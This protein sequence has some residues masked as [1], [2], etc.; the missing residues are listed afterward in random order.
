MNSRQILVIAVI[1]VI[2]VAV[3]GV[4]FFMESA[5]P[6]GSSGGEERISLNSYQVKAGNDAPILELQFSKLLGMGN[7]V[8]VLNNKFQSVG[9]WV[10]GV[11]S[12]TEH[13]DTVEISSISP[14]NMIGTYYVLVYYKASIVL[15]KTIYFNAPTFTVVKY[16]EDKDVKGTSA[17]INSINITVRDDDIT[18]FYYTLLKWKFDGSNM[19]DE[20]LP[21]EH[22]TA[23]GEK[24]VFIPLQKMTTTGTHSITVY[25]G[26]YYMSTVKITLTISV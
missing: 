3:I 12:S 24:T 17:Y 19:T 10:Y 1:V 16:T 9:V 14:P 5:G 11:D 2:I 22:I 18:P 4:I 21:I 8:K 26:Y 7:S 23:G 13:G 6:S 25:F 15:N 20:K